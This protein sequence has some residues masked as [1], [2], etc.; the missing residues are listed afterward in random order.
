MKPF[1]WP[2]ATSFA[3]TIVMSENVALPIQRFRPFSTQWSPSRRAVV[4][5]PFAESEPE[6]GSV[7]PNAPITSPEA[8]LGIHS[9]RCACEPAIASDPPTR[10]FCTPTNVLTD[11]SM[12]ASSR[13]TNP[14]NTAEFSNGRVS[15]QANDSVPRS[16][17]GFT[18]WCGNSA[19]S[20]YPPMIGFTS[21]SPHSRMAAIA[22]CS[23]SVSRADSYE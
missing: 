7:S 6:S 13:A 10:P 20:Q 16:A 4:R 3:Q 11:G 21:R 9:S 5:R 23:R 22:C 8:I 18:I 2:S 1:T 14:R 17:S 12:R 15:S 19:R